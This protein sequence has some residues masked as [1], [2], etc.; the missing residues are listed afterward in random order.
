MKYSGKPYAKTDNRYIDNLKLR[1]VLTFGQIIKAL[2]YHKRRPDFVQQLRNEEDASYEPS[3]LEDKNDPSIWKPGY[4]N[5]FFEQLEEE[6]NITVPKKKV[7]RPRALGVFYKTV[8]NTIPWFKHESI[9]D[10]ALN[11][12]I[13]FHGI[14]AKVTDFTKGDDHPTITIKYKYPIID[15]TRINWKSPYMYMLYGFLSGVIAT[16]IY[17]FI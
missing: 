8:K 14:P 15:L 5:W 10:W 12:N 4:W 16:L 9:G 13:I 2:E 6:M 1:K 7:K 17:F 11:Q 3:Q